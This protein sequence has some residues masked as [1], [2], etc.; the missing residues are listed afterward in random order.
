MD[1]SPKEEFMEL[2]KKGNYDY[3]HHQPSKCEILYDVLDYIL[4]KINLTIGDR[5]DNRWDS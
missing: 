4:N 2:I 1:S 5:E 3:Y